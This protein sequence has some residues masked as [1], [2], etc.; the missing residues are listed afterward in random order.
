MARVMGFNPERIRHIVK[1]E[2][3][4]LGNLN[5]KVIGEDVESITVKFKRPSSLKPSALIE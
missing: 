1:S 5:P 2:R 3:F 4:D